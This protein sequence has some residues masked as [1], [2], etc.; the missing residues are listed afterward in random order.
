MAKEA[1][2]FSHD[3]NARHDP[4]VTAMR[5][6]YGSEGYGWY[7]M[8]VEMMRESEGYK[9]DMHGKYVWNAFALQLQCDSSR[10]EEFVKDCIHEFNLFESDDRSFWSPS[11]L[12]RMDL[13]EQKS[14]VRRKAANAR[15]SK[16]KA[17]S[18]DQVSNADDMQMHSNSNAN[19]MQGKES[20]GKE[21][22]RKVKET[23]DKTAFEAYTSNSALIDSLNS[24]LEMRK[25]IKKPMTDRAITL[26]LGKLDKQGRDDEHK[27]K[28]L[29]QSVLNCWQDIYELKEPVTRAGGGNNQQWRS[30]KQNIPIVDDKPAASVSDAELEELR[31]LA[32]KIDGKTERDG[33]F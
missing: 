26:M 12:R 28:L 20:K 22:K 10:V 14:E 16:E 18:G 4:K 6:A 2:Y 19:G 25:K 23:T 17:A 7:W 1:Y 30:G 3:S 9:L 33:E 21:N 27:I 8:L 32:R 11:L 24:F 15:W 29:E 5:G 13:R 31:K